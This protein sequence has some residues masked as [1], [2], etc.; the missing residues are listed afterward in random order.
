MRKLILAVCLTLGVCLPGLASEARADYPQDRPLNIIVPFGPGGAVDIAGRILAEY[1]QKEFKITINV[2]NKPGG[3]QAIGLNDMLRAR[4]DGYTLC[5]PAFGGLCTT[6]KLTNVG[7]TEKD[8]KPVAQVT[9]MELA[10]SVNKASGLKDFP[11]FIEAA[12]KNP[13][14]IVYG[15][16]GAITTQRLYLTRLLQRF[17]NGLKIRHAAYGSGHEVSTALL[18]K[19]ITAGFQVPANVLPY[20]ES[21]DFA[22]IAVT[23]KTRHP[24]LPDTPTFRE[25]YADRLSPEDEQWIDMGSWHG[26]V[27][28]GK[29][30]DERIAALQPLLQKAL[31]DPDVIARF[32]KIG[33]SVDYLPPKEFGEVIAAGSALVD[34]V[35]AGRKSLD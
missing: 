34:D 3:A 10:F 13:A 24:S 8:F 19:H 1:F 23:R 12:Q 25:I 32:K 9:V 29:V 30:P 28:S 20:V 31:A 26:L 17:H 16:T 4:P 5:F 11:A 22:T 27:A 18:G 33:L 21:G 15:S 6:P 2:I 14:D 7:F 35:L